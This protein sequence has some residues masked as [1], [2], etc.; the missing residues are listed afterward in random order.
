ME[1]G[2][3]SAMALGIAAVGYF[4]IFR[5]FIKKKYCKR[6]GR[7]FLVLCVILMLYLLTSLFYQPSSHDY[8]AQLLVFGSLCIPACYIGMRLAREDYFAEMMEVLPFFVTITAFF[9]SRAAIFASMQ[10]VLLGKGDDEVAFN[11]QNASY[12]LAFSYAYSFF[13]VFYYKTEQK[14]MFNRF[15]HLLMFVL[16]FVCAAGCLVSGGRGAFVYM[17]LITGYMFCKLIRRRGR[18]RAKYYVALVIGVIGSIYFA[19][20]FG[21]FDTAGFSRIRGSFMADESREELWKKAITAFVK[22]PLFGN[23]LGSVWWTVGY[24]SHN[25][26]TDLLCEAGALGSFVALF[27]LFTGL[28]R[29]IKWSKTSVF[30]F[31]L[32]VVMLGSLVNDMFSGYWI[33]SYKMFLVLGYVYANK[34]AKTTRALRSGPVVV[35]CNS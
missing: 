32:L 1:S 31:F 15:C 35:L 33:S 30:D 13:Y 3:K 7:E 19:N 16:I 24:R 11:Y 18:G 21:L 5:D 22:S 23:G 20:K 27:I 8:W 6:N 29:L 2:M 12:F 26:L 17:I 25:F 28:C 9:V 14:R 4:C 10:G 34:R